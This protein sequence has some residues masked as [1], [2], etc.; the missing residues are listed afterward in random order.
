MIQSLPKIEIGVSNDLDYD[1][2]FISTECRLM[3]DIE[4]SLKRLLGKINSLYIN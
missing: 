2:Y 3:L 4:I 1:N